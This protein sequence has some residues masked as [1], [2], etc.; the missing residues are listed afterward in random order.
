MTAGTAL[1]WAAHGIAGVYAVTTD[2]AQRRQ[3]I[4]ATVTHAA[5]H[6]GRE[7]SAC[8]SP[9]CRPPA[10]ACLVYRRLGFSVVGEY[11]LFAVPAREP[12]E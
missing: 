2:A 10:T 11:G 3:G 7:L 8:G 5:V 4:G 6:A 12:A 9:R 1:R